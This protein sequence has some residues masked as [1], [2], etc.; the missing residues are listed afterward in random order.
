MKNGKRDVHI[1]FSACFSIASHLR[2]SVYSGATLKRFAGYFKECTRGFS[3]IRVV[4]RAS[5]NDNPLFVCRAQDNNLF[6]VAEHSNLGIM[7]NDNDLSTLLRSPEDR[8]DTLIDELRVKVIL[9]LVN[10]Q[11]SVAVSG[12]HNSEKYGLLLAK[13]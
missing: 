11:R 10:N 12:E 9:R 1:T 6:S 8:Y 13:R 5:R 4:N 7:C 2:H 3:R